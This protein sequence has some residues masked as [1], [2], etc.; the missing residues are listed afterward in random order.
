M[1]PQ[2]VK[3]TPLVGSVNQSLAR[4]L[5]PMTAVV[6]AAETEAVVPS[7]SQVLPVCCDLTTICS[8]RP[9]FT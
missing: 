2:K 5:G 4:Q 3:S 7:E 9:Q 6:R 1:N 8:Y